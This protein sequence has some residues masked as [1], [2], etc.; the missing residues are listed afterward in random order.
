[1]GLLDAIAILTWLTAAGIVVSV[2][3]ML[4][5]RWHLAHS[6][7]RMATVLALIVLLPQVLVVA[8]CIAAPST[9]WRAMRKISPE[10]S[11]DDPSQHARLLAQGLSE[12]MNVGLL[13]LPIA[14][15]GGLLWSVAA[16]RIV[17]A[18]EDPTRGS[19]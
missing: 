2:A 7:A 17:R 10:P 5:K 8:L 15:L 1:M 11:W 9:M 12:L 18:K 19:R 3:A 14:V 4:A 6:L 13:S 16:R